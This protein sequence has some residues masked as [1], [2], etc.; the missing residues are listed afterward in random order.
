MTAYV[1]SSLT[2]NFPCWSEYLIPN[3][4]SI[5]TA[6]HLLSMSG[7][8]HVTFSH[9]QLHIHSQPHLCIWASSSRT[10]TTT[11]TYTFPRPQA[12]PRPSWG[13]HARS[14]QKRRLL[15][16]PC[17]SMQVGHGRLCRAAPGFEAVLLDDSSSRALAWAPPFQEVQPPPSQLTPP[18]SFAF[19]TSDR[20]W[21]LDPP[22]CSIFTC[23]Q[24]HGLALC[25]RQVR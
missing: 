23:L 5:P 22:S 3:P 24:E 12:S 17:R 16:P 9:F 15:G 14:L 20:K 2:C 13:D 10:H 6:S 25:H 8:D 1:N 4:H 18:Q 21:H 19:K 7:S 11:H